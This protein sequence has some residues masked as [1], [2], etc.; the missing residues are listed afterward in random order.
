MGILLTGEPSEAQRGPQPELDVDLVLV[1][2]DGVPSALPA[3]FLRAQWEVFPDETRE[4]AYDH[5][6][7]N[8]FVFDVDGNGVTDGVLAR[9]PVRAP[10]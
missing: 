1:D 2:A 6:Q 7:I 4:E 9:A 10:Q 5:L 8:F 3:G